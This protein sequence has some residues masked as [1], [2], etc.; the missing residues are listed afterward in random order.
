MRTSL[1]SSPLPSS[2]TRVAEGDRGVP[3]VLMVGSLQA[4]G[5]EYRW[6]VGQKRTDYFSQQAALIVFE[7]LWGRGGCLLLQDETVRAWAIDG[8]G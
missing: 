5:R 7:R 1:P 8:C 4:W 6:T 3:R 2:M